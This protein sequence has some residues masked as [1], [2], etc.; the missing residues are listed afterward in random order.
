MIHP[1]EVRDS[2]VVSI[3]TELRIRHDTPVSI[4]SLLQKETS[5]LSAVTPRFPQSPAPAPG[6]LDPL[7]VAGFAC[8]GHSRR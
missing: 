8:S 1:F 4:L 2:V 5:C 6:N 7:P 3:F